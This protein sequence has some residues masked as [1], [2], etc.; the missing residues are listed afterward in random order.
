MQIQKLFFHNNK[1]QKLAAK[2]Y[3]D[4]PASVNGIIYCHGMLS[5]K[6]GYKITHMAEDIVNAG[7]TL[8][9]FD[10]S[11]VGESEGDISDLSI[12]QEV[13]DLNCAYLF[14]QQCGIQNIHLVG[15]SMGALVSF[16]FSSIMRDK[17]CSQTLIAAPVLLDQLMQTIAGVD[18]NTLPDNG[19]TEVEGNSV[20][21]KFF[22]EAL[23]LD[24]ET[25][26]KNTAVPA[27]VIHGGKDAA[28]P[29]I[30]AAVL[31]KS[32]PCEKRIVLIEDGDHSLMRDSDIEI[33][34]DN[35]IEWAREHSV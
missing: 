7:F 27:L 11:C 33:L 26:L 1:S 24:I 31:T 30:N 20:K 28:V 6:D 8:F 19:R 13:D 4:E 10:F 15:S 25:A 16:L 9:T 2:I 34:R 21:N 22:K 12:L 5:T 17:L 32:I 18:I 29:V 14:F 23:K 3:K 35:I